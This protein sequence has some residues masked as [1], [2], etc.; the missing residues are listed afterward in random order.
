MKIWLKSE[1]L[2][3]DLSF[4][5]LHIRNVAFDW[6][7]SIYVSTIFVSLT[8]I[9]AHFYTNEK[10]IISLLFKYF[11]IKRIIAKKK[12]YKT[13]NAVENILHSND[14]SLVFINFKK[15]QVKRYFLMKIP[16][17]QMHFFICV[18]LRR[19]SF[20]SAFGCL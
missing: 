4:K 16:S 18:I 19:Y 14:H 15:K 10:N 5:D 2:W 7:I 13:T 9:V 11:T 17:S 8:L 20:H 1:F 3:C 6:C 12:T